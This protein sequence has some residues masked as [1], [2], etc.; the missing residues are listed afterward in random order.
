MMTHLG[1]RLLPA[2]HIN[3]FLRQDDEKETV[4]KIEMVPKTPNAL[5]ATKKSISEVFHKSEHSVAQPIIDYTPEYTR[6]NSRSSSR[7]SAAS[8]NK[9][10]NSKKSSLLLLRSLLL[11]RRE[12]YQCDDVVEQIMNLINSSSPKSLEVLDKQTRSSALLLTC[13]FNNHLVVSCALSV[14]GG[15]GV[16]FC[17]KDN[18][19]CL[20]VAV[21]NGNVE[22]VKA[23]LN[24]ASARN[25]NNSSVN[26]SKFYGARKGNGNGKGN[27]GG[28]SKIKDAR[29]TI[30][31]RGKACI[32]CPFT[33]A[34]ALNKG[35][36]VREFL[37]C[38][39][40]FFVERSA[41]HTAYFSECLTPSLL[42]LS[43]AFTSVDQGESL[44]C[45]L[46]SVC[47]R[48]E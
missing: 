40:S 2:L 16:Y 34:V 35:E 47:W 21:K 3:I 15:E 30:Y 44:P 37:L 36:M 42:Y 31:V 41:K 13:R 28:G 22:I 20:R 18:E 9:S 24:I 43:T 11:N 26:R 45:S 33:L 7:S 25:N 32:Y 19:T 4:D 29:T 5:I 8:F 48:C 6:Q 39:V 38:L 46:R 10:G 12:H 1:L 27:G 23:L 14:V 17:D